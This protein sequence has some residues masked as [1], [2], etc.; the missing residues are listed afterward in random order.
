MLLA[1]MLAGASLLLPAAPSRAVTTDAG[2]PAAQ[3]LCQGYSMCADRGY[4]HAG[5]AT[6]NRNMYWQMYSGTNCTNYVA[7]RM[8]QAGMANRRPWPVRPPNGN[9]TYWGSQMSS[10]TDRTP[11]VGAVAWWRANVPGAGSAGHVAYV[12][13]VISP[14]E[15]LISE[16]NY[17]SSF[18]WRRITSRGPWPS[19]FIHFRDVALKPTVAPT[20]V[21]TPTVGVALRSTPGSWTPAGSYSYQWTANGVPIAGATRTTFTP[22]ATQLGKKIALKVTATKTSY[23]PGASTSVTTAA[24]APGTQAVQTQPTIEGTAQVDQELTADTGAYSPTPERATVQWLANGAAI[25]GATRPTFVPGQAQAGTRLT[26]AVTTARAGYTTKVTMSKATAPVLAP[27]IEILQPGGITGDRVVRQRLTASA[28]VLDPSDAK[29]TYTWFRNG[30][31][32]PGATNRT[33]T[34]QLGDIGASVSAR[35]ALTR[36][37]YRNKTVDLA[38]VDGIKAPVTLG[39]KTGSPRARRAIVQVTATSLGRTRPTG[40]VTITIAGQRQTVSLVRGVAQ[41][42]FDELRGGTRTVTVSY[43]GDTRTVAGTATGTV[44]VRPRGWQ[45]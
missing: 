26:V 45:P 30:Q 39:L 43:A 35:V 3:T 24:T 34:L 18:S 42:R 13:R 25:P 21:G 15:I 31:P 14:T 11:M 1:A 12:E 40:E 32:I 27:D 38:P 44:T 36:P 23:A 2:T 37:G 29:A 17:G 33:Y 19:G 7:F 20:V 4:S 9:A 5:Y 10:I 8:V 41:V 16:S 6:A 28:G 22:D